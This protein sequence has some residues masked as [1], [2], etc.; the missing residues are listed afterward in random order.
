MSNPEKSDLE[1]LKG[2][3]EQFDD[4]TIKQA[5]KEMKQD[6]SDGGCQRSYRD[7]DDP[8]PEV[9]L[10]EDSRIKKEDLGYIG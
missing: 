5:A 2:I 7:F 1:Q 3:L 8:G 6:R 4:E 9:K 10:G